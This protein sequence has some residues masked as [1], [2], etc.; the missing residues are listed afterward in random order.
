MALVLE[1][2]RRTTPEP[3]PG[4]L[5]WVKAT[6]LVFVTAMLFGL[7]DKLPD[8]LSVTL[9]NGLLLI[10]FAL[11][12]QGS[13]LHFGVPM[14]WR[15]W[16]AMWLVCMPILA[17]YTHAEPS[18]RGRS[19]VMLACMA[20]IM[21]Y[22]A[23]FLFGQGRQRKSGMSFGVRFAAVSL[24]GIMLVFVLRWVHVVALPQDGSHL[25]A[26]N[27]VQSAYTLSYSLAVLMLTVGLA[28]M[29]S[30]RVRESFQFQATHD[31]LTG[32]L[33][34]RAALDALAREL[35]RSQRYQRPFAV[36]M[37]DLD[38][39]KAVNDRHGH[40]VG[41]QV[42]QRFVQRVSATLR[43]NDVL[44][45]FGGEEFVVMLPETNDA[46]AQA[47]AERVRQ[48]VRQP[49]AALPTVSVS[50]GLTDWQTH[51]RSVDALIERSDRALYL[52]KSRGRDR[53]ETVN[54]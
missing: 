19:V 22:H 11:Y 25:F 47:T 41:D 26:P 46:S 42:L 12:L 45:R 35:A 54:T 52:A 10:S 21:G 8:V 51:D 24:T 17:W 38:H 27:W 9:S 20:T 40:Q 48:A 30:E 16:V 44:G 37:L 3:V 7:R 23:W 28:L 2:L 49:D 5:Q 4:L 39:F 6:A 53:V 43:P 31:M 1:L 33:N 13:H 15:V 18:F 32:A 50:I 36:L 29:A 34:R 14:R